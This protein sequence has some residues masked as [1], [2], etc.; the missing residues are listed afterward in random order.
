MLA[1]ILCTRRV[2]LPGKAMHFT[3]AMQC[4]NC[5]PHHASSTFLFFDAIR[6][7][8]SSVAILLI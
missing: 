8:L 1:A 4:E 5:P 2:E 6:R 7:L 3:I